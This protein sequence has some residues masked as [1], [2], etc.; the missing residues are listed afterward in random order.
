MSLRTPRQQI[1]T[2][3][4]IINKDAT[5]RGQVIDDDGRLCAIGGLAHY[6]A[7]V[8]KR[9]LRQWRAR[10]RG[11]STHLAWEAAVKKFPVLK[12]TN[13][14]SVYEVNDRYLNVSERR[15]ALCRLFRGVLP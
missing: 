15:Q 3:C 2:I 8:P 9:T 10:A 1:A 12:C 7:G 5:G 11:G 4:R 6:G 13:E 14:W